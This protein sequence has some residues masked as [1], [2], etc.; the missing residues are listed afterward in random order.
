MQLSQ[1]GY[2]TRW[3]VLLAAWAIAAFALF[4]QAN[5]VRRYLDVVGQVGTRGAPTVNT[6]M[7]Q[8]YPA[9][10]ADAQTW[11][12][13]ALSLIEG[14]DL[15]LRHTTI[16]NAP[17]GREV[18][19]NSAWAWSI[20]SAGWIY[21]LFSG[22]PVTT[23]VE[24]ATV[25]L[26]PTVFLAL[27]AI[28]SA[29]VTRRA[30][31]LAGV[32]VV[33]AMV[34]NDRVFEGFFPT[35][36]DHHG[37]LTVAVFGLMLGGVMMGGGWWQ[38][39]NRRSS[40][41]PDSADLTRSA[42]VFS[43]LSGALG[44]WVSA[45]S[46]IPA[47]VLVATAGV[48]ALFI[49]G[50]TA[51]KNGA[52]FEPES[53]RT[54]GRVGALASLVFYLLEYFPNH[55]GFRLEANHPLHALAWL[56]GGELIAQLGEWWL[57]PRGNYRVNRQRL[58]SGIIAVC[59]APLTVAIG[60]AKV[61]VILHPF[62]SRLHND[63]IQEF[64]PIWRTLQGFNARMGFQLL[65]VDSAP[66]I[67]GIATLSFLR[68]ES[69]IVLWFA[70]FAA[71]FFNA[72]AWWQSRWLLNASGIQIC[73]G[74]VVL[75]CWTRSW[76][77][78]ARWTLATVLMGA[79]YVPTAVIRNLN[80]EHDLTTRQVAQGDAGNALARDIALKLRAS[81]PQGDIVLLTS[82]NASTGIG[83]Y[84]RFK[85]LGTLYWENLEGLQS[86]ASIFAAESERQAATLLRAHKVTH[87]A[88]VSQEN[89][90]QQYFQLLN[91]K[92]TA[93]EL[94]RTF[95]V[96][97][98]YDKVVPQWLE[99]IPYKVP[100]DLA[101]LKVSVMLF[102]VNFKQSLAEAIYNVA[103]SQI[104]SGSVD[105]ADRT[106]DLLL[107]KL[108]QAHQPWLRK[109]ELLMARRDW[110]SAADCLLRGITLAPAAEHGMLFTTYAKPFYDAKQYALAIRFYRA[111]LAD[112]KTA[113]AACYLAWVLST[114]PDATV[115]NGKEALALA[116]EAV[117]IDPNSPSFLSAL[118]AALA[119]NGRFP[120]AVETANRALANS[121]LRAEPAN[122]QQ[123]FTERLATLKASKPIRVEP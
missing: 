97:V 68:R 39:R 15:R 17:D 36:V 35:Y 122:V 37:L 73:L 29:W 19:W 98:F 18:H 99:M 56:G 59:I 25:W 114:N 45:A 51:Q 10:A 46:V 49:N 118:A 34:G 117:K 30:G 21:H 66:L 23:S 14:N 2:R 31:L 42:A 120:E 121:R 70:T 28:L 89:F 81:Q 84:G 58:L 104:E 61:F 75:A 38:P 65:V 12:R 76:L 95:G 102:K 44:L 112:Q 100:D 86:A 63:Y 1:E 119:E 43:A 40:V 74:L 22:Q 54:W 85:T 33:A 50:H 41:L 60:G 9:F 87:I 27:I 111:A 6:P 7:R 79:L 69:P 116:N 90:I 83:Y 77:P 4:S 53:W 24:R 13:H 5:S 67:A 88:I 47:I 62:M 20:A 32:F 11:V 26:N 93:E 105:E 115:R 82:P 113:D 72:L 55:L 3:I 80:N 64:L 91:P 107:Q 78:S 108:P 8:M 92:G 71:L 57:A 103:L 52:T 48:L 101:A 106:L 109:G 94:R 16:D 123:I 110:V 96:R